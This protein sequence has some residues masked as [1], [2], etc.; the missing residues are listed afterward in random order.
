[1]PCSHL[2]DER[3]ARPHRVS[4]AG[5]GLSALERY[6]ALRW[7]RSRATPAVAPSTPRS[8]TSKGFPTFSHMEGRFT[9]HRRASSSSDLTWGGAGTESLGDAIP[10]EALT[11]VLERFPSLHPLRQ[12]L[13]REALLAV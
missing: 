13:L 4:S 5:G 6:R 7:S 9:A 2:P 10:P 8:L 12:L 1:M 11:L 3:P